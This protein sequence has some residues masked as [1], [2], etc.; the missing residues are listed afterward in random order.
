MV[1]PDELDEDPKERD[2]FREAW[3]EITEAQELAEDDVSVSDTGD[4]KETMPDLN[5]DEEEET[6]LNEMMHEE[7]SE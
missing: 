6:A 1:F 4:G 2:E 7:D 3:F 5:D